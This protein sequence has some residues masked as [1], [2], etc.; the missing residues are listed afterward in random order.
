MA[1][2]HK[3]EFLETGY[4]CEIGEGPHWV[5]KEQVLYYVDINPGRVCRYD[6]KTKEN[7]FVNVSKY[8]YL[9]FVCVLFN[10]RGQIHR[11]LTT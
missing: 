2:T 10:I 4:V 1:A 5:E 11:C 6:P 8:Q 9:T 7:S 3:A